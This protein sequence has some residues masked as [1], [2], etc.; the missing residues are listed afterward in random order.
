MNLFKRKEEPK[1]EIMAIVPIDVEA[2]TEKDNEFNPLV[3]SVPEVKEY[4]VREFEKTKGLLN[5]IDGL[6]EKL[7]AAEEFKIKYD[8]AMV[9]VDGYSTKLA[10]LEDRMT[11]LQE[12]LSKEK[13]SHTKTRDELNSYKIKFNNIS[14]TKMQIKNEIVKEIKGEIILAIKAHKGALS[15]SVACEIVDKTKLPMTTEKGNGE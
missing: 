9:T 8:A 3:V 15:K 11:K 6:N 10:D 12:K 5:I 1:D 4:L 7:E 13:E 14:L 2:E